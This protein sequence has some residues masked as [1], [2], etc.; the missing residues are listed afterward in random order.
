M[1]SFLIELRAKSVGDREKGLSILFRRE[2]TKTRSFEAEQAQA[3]KT[4]MFSEVSMTAKSD[5]AGSSPAGGAK[6]FRTRECAEF[7]LFHFSFFTLHFSLFTKPACT[8]F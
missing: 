8:E 1:R 7:L 2:I 6:K 3:R 5:V 4:T